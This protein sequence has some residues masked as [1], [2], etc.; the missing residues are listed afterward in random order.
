MTD[1][2]ITK[3][4]GAAMGFLIRTDHGEDGIWCNDSLGNNVGIY[5]PLHD[6]AQAM[7]LVKRLRLTISSHNHMFYCSKPQ[8]GPEQWKFHSGNTDLNRAICETVARIQKAKQK[9]TV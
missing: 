2:E 5:A 8:G 3:L 1:L 7:A 4:C 9:D 6:D